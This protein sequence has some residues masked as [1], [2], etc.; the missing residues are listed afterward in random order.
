VKQLKKEMKALTK[1][2]NALTR[3][4]EKIAKKLEKLEKTR[5]KAIPKK[6]LKP[7]RSV[8]K[9]AAKKAAEKPTEKKT[10]KGAVA[11]AVMGVVQAN[12]EGV[13]TFEIMEQ[14]SLTK[15]QVWGVINRAKKE[16][17]VKSEKRGTYVAV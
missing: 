15:T 12:S 7:K 4:T 17:K 5:V 14:T 1:E 3:K 13:S 2:L 8:K 16:G 10:A 9:P 6:A 11:D